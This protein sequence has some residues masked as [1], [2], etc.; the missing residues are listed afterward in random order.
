MRRLERAGAADVV[1]IGQTD[2]TVRRFGAYAFWQGVF[3]SEVAAAVGDTPDAPEAVA[4]AEALEAATPES[5][6]EVHAL[7]AADGGTFLQGATRDGFGNV[8]PPILDLSE[9]S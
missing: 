3:L 8:E 7:I 6:A 4:V 2:G 1:S 5:L 9:T